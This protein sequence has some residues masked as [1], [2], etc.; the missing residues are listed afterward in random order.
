MST[1]S[2]LN[3]IDESRALKVSSGRNSMESDT[4]VCA[5]GKFR[6]Q[7]DLT[8]S[9]N[10]NTRIELHSFP[11]KRKYKGD[12]FCNIIIY[13]Y[14]FREYGIAILNFYLSSIFSYTSG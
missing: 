11:P 8:Q 9:K 14:I 12:S 7:D 13:I 5:N 1:N 10:K 3:H 4:I 6:S 2:R